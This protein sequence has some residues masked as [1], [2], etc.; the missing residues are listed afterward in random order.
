MSFVREH[1]VKRFTRSRGWNKVRKAHI[2]EHPYCEACGSRKKL[3]V[4][5][6]ADFSEHPELELNPA[7]LMTLCMSGTR[8]HLTFGHLGNFKSIN[9]DIVVDAVMYRTKV[10]NRR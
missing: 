4:H 5:H 1:I 6:I 8:C 7:N 9:P 2:K 10:K 3:Q